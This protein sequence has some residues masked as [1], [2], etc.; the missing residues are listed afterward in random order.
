[1]PALEFPGRALAGGD[2][3]EGAPLRFHPD[4]GISRKHGARDVPQRCS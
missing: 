2:L 3:I 1:M 4:V